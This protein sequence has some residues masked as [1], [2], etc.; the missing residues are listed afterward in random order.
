MTEESLFRESDFSPD[1]LSQVRTE[2][3]PSERLK[4]VGQPR[5]APFVRGTIPMVIF[6]IPW[7]AFSI[8][9]M[10]VA[11]TL[12]PP[13][14][15]GW[16]ILLRLGVG[17]FS[18]PFVLLG[19][20]LLSSPWWMRN[21]A[22][23]TCYAIT[24]QRAILWEP[25]FVGYVSIRSYKPAALGS[26]DTSENLDGSGSL[27]FERRRRG[28]QGVVQHGFM[29]IDKV[30]PV[31]RLLREVLLTRPRE[32]MSAQK[33]DATG[34]VSEKPSSAPLGTSALIALWALRMVGIACVMAGVAPIA[35]IIWGDLVLDEPI[36]Y[37]LLPILSLMCITV[38]LVF[39]TRG[40]AKPEQEASRPKK[41]SRELPTPVTFLLGVVF[42]LAGLL[43]VTEGLSQFDTMR[44]PA[45]YERVLDDD[46]YDNDEVAKGVSL[47]RGSVRIRGGFGEGVGTFMGMLFVTI[48]LGI[49]SASVTRMMSLPGNLVLR[50][51][52]LIHAVA[53]QTIGFVVLW[54]YCTLAPVFEA[55]PFL[56][57]LIY[58]LLG[59]ISVALAIPDSRKHFRSAVW[60]AMG[61]GF[62][63]AFAGALIGGVVG[64]VVVV[65]SRALARGIMG[66]EWWVYAAI[67]GGLITG[68][69]FGVLRLTGW[70]FSLD[71]D[72]STPKEATLRT[73]RLTTRRWLTARTVELAAFF[74]ILGPLLMAW[75]GLY[76]WLVNQG[77]DPTVLQYL[78]WMVFVG[79]WLMTGVS[80]VLGAAKPAKRF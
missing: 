34:P 55:W 27:V 68:L 77:A 63:G 38:G 4:W 78:W 61:G 72:R 9:F 35:A 17:L 39:L 67:A 65:T 76:N 41:S 49:S 24:N 37:W 18:C 11:V 31:E 15:I 8:G 12:S 79:G 62:V 59:L 46:A 19:L 21:R 45:K 32:E 66:T 22:Q 29:H 47:V 28:R 50:G 74:C 60:Y 3:K 73:P 64:G 10:A 52:A 54:R 48:G 13:I 69:A 40:P 44:E 5:I 14:P 20:A 6:G 30:R 26:I 71:G 70:E 57:I 7:T 1:L 2:L 25:D 33:G 43:G 80:K 16:L 53:W 42:L 56:V 51:V 36:E 23:Q 58:E 75:T